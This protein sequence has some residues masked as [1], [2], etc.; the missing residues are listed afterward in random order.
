MG[1][2]LHEGDEHITR[3]AFNRATSNENCTGLAKIVGRLKGSIN[4]DFQSKCW[5]KSRNLG[6]LC[7]NF[8]L[9][10]YCSV[11]HGRSYRGFPAQAEL[12]GLHAAGAGATGELGVGAG[13]YPIVTLQY[14]STTIFI[15]G[16]LSDSVAV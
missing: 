12:G 5:A 4:R 8:V 10:Q 3:C 15:P 2:H 11:L 16:F 9:V 13:L 14:S 7:T 1:D 6:Q